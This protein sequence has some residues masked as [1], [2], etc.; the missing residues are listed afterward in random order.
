MKEL[1]EM[2]ENRITIAETR[3]Q[4]AIKGENWGEANNQSYMIA[5]FEETLMLAKNIERKNNFKFT[6]LVWKRNNHNNKYDIEHSVQ[7]GRASFDVL[8]SLAGTSAQHDATNY[9]DFF[10]ELVFQDGEDG[11]IENVD[12]FYIDEDIF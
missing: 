9:P 7:E 12:F 8:Q 10:V 1:I 11:E 2:L 4:K 6:T 3:K 5:A